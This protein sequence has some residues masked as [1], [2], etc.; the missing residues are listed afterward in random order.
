MYKSD[1]STISKICSSFGKET[2]S[3]NLKNKNNGIPGPGQYEIHKNDVC[4]YLR[5][6]YLVFR[7]NHDQQEKKEGKVIGLLALVLIQ[8]VL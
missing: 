5:I 1:I 7:R 8:L 4:Q 2:K 6:I 3:S